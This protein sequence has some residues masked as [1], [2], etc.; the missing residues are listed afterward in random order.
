MDIIDRIDIFLEEVKAKKTPTSKKQY[1]GKYYRQN[2]EKV[3]R[4][5]IELNRSIEGKKRK[6][7]RPYMKKQQKTPTG[8]H[9]V[10]YS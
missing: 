1:A 7:M 8:R 10:N 3:K 5:R 4:N 2:K 9:K 6:R